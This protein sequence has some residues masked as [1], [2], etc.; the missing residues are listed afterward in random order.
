MDKFNILIE[1]NASY[2]EVEDSIADVLEAGIVIEKNLKDGF[3][4]QDLFAAIQLQPAVNEIINDAPLFWEQFMQL[5]PDTAKAAVLGAK[6]RI[7]QSGRTFGK[8]TQ[9]LINFLY[10]GASNY[11][12]ALDSYQEGQRQYLMWQMLFK[13]EPV[14]PRMEN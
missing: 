2:S 9:F 10:V 11:G 14:I 7:E 5:Q 12:F 6:R 8:V 13:G 3:Q 4:F 1:K